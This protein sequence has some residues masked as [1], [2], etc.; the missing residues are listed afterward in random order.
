M[1]LENPVL[2]KEMRVRMRGGRAY[3]LMAAYVATLGAFFV[4][5]YFSTLAWH[6]MMNNTVNPRFAQE[7]G[8]SFYVAM[9]IVQTVLGV[10]IAPALTSGALTIE[11]EQRS[12]DLL[13]ISLMRP[14]SIVFGKLVSALSFIMLLVFASAPLVSVCFMLGGV[15][16]R[17]FGAAYAVIIGSAFFF[18][19]IGLFCSSLTQRTTTATMLAYGIAFFFA[20]GTAILA[21]FAD[22]RFGTWNFVSQVL[23]LLNP[24]AVI[25]DICYGVGRGGFFPAPTGILPRWGEML[26]LYAMTSLPLLWIAV[27]RAKPW[28]EG[29]GRA[30][31]TST[32]STTSSTTRTTTMSEM[33]RLMTIPAKKSAPARSWS[34]PFEVANPVLKRELLSRLRGRQTRRQRVMRWLLNL[35]IGG[36]YLYFLYVMFSYN[37]S[38]NDW[39]GWWIGLMFTQLFLVSIIAPVI[40][41][42]AFTVEKE[43]RTME[44]LRL[45]RLTAWEICWGKLCGRL[46]SIVILMVVFLPAIFLAATL[47]KV[48]SVAFSGSYSLVVTTSFALGTLGLTCSALFRKTGTAMAVAMIATVGVL[49]FVPLVTVLLLETN[50]IREYGE[51]RVIFETV[52]GAISPYFAMEIL[53]ETMPHW[54]NAQEY[55]Y[56]IW[57]LCCGLFSFA[58]L[59]LVYLTCRSFNSMART[60]R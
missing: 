3:W 30:R 25:G 7:L 17:E 44:M 26:I 36:L 57:F 6:R 35:T 2:L 56:G 45:T 9:S 10:L 55:A 15:D 51:T 60:E 50:Y 54:G 41:A 58:G 12:F 21:V 47:G 14:R 8:R 43:Q 53:S 18:G 34:L 38:A 19:I 5:M 28:S 29:E 22:W 49:L 4:I 31:S 42:S 24:F 33:A 39:A 40:C 46:A 52:I 1:T 32:S 16:L 48:N 23:M 20:A 59:F 37:T 13:A 27:R 11:R